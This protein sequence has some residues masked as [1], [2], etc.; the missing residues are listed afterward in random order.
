MLREVF[1]Y[2]AYRVTERCNAL[3]PGCF[4]RENDLPPDPSIHQIVQVLD[5][6]GEANM[7]IIGVM[8]G[9]PGI[10]KDLK[11]ILQVA[12]SKYFETIISTNGMLISNERLD[13]MARYID[14]LSLSLDGSTAF[15]NDRERGLGQWAAA[16][17]LIKHFNPQKHGFQ[18]KINTLVHRK[19]FADIPN[20]PALFEGKPVRW[21]LLQ[22][23]PR[24]SGLDVKDDF[25]ITKEEFMSLGTRMQ[26]MFPHQKI[27]L[28]DYSIDEPPDVLI[29]RPNGNLLINKGEVYE[30][31]GNAYTEKIG[32]VIARTR[33]IYPSYFE[34]NNEEFTNSYR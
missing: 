32:D 13:D 3:C 24:L 22:F 10:R 4:S 9:E 5:N 17:R 33:Q 25:S 34:E 29:I 6:L 14:F 8:G 16:V 2:P 1:T 7:D 26:N 15:L 30:V 18:L 31:I 23:T 11:R 28:R 12:K 21:K 20:I 19:N 27:T